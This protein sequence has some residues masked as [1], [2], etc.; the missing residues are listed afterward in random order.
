MASLRL[1]FPSE[2]AGV[3]IP[4]VTPDDV[5]PATWLKELAVEVAMHAGA[6]AAGSDA[7]I[8]QAERVYHV[9]GKGCSSVRRVLGTLAATADAIAEVQ[10][11]MT[12]VM[13]LFNAARNPIA[14][15]ES[16]DKD[17][18][19]T[20][21]R[22]VEHIL[23]LA[24]VLL[25]IGDV[26]KD[27][28]VAFEVLSKAAQ[29][30][31][32]KVNDVLDE[33][34]DLFVTAMDFQRALHGLEVFSE[35]LVWLVKELLHIKGVLAPILKD[36][37]QGYLLP[38]LDAETRKVLDAMH[39]F[40]PAWTQNQKLYNIG[41]FFACESLGKARIAWESFQTCVKSCCD[42]IQVDVPSWLGDSEDPLRDVIQPQLVAVQVAPGGIDAL[43]V[44]LPTS[45]LDASS[46]TASCCHSA[47]RACGGGTGAD[48]EQQAGAPHRPARGVR[49]FF[50]LV[51][52]SLRCHH[53]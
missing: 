42:G 52:L 53:L 49:A 34:T 30:I 37:E 9:L 14:A 28:G 20:C 41:R 2:V 50:E 33:F 7:A 1:P 17:S 31:I 16:L 4:P 25:S 19:A 32:D 23:N 11:E 15:F 51:V 3:A 35:Q 5:T 6:R 38:S 26:L 10:G 47:V 36:L 29:P 12:P 13:P 45:E 40:G 18:L 27:V 22:A 24:T 44:L 21:I 8:E 48:A 39:R 43:D 46:F